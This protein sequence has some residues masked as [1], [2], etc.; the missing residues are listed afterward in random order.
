MHKSC[1]VTAMHSHNCSNFHTV[2]DNGWHNDMPLVLEDVCKLSLSR[3]GDR[4]G[5][6]AVPIIIKLVLGHANT[7]FIAYICV[8]F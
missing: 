8:A 5:F 4:N 7:Y 6:L 3:M 2:F 1:L